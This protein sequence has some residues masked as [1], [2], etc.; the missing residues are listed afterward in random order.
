[1]GV[2][3]HPSNQKLPL[4]IMTG[5]DY[6][7]CL[8]R[9][10]CFDSYN[11]MRREMQTTWLQRLPQCLYI[12]L[13]VCVCVCVCVCACVCVSQL[14]QKLSKKARRVMGLQPTGLAFGRLKG[15]VFAWLQ[16]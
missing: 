3:T 6:I 12:Q 4:T 15:A 14:V 9:V 10:L 2:F 8:L 7:H 5:Q 11:C 16:V 13:C 1:M